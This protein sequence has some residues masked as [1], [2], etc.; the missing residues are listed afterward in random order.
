M[1]IYFGRL[2]IDIVQAFW[3]VV[4]VAVLHYDLVI[5]N[6]HGKRLRFMK[7]SINDI[8]SQKKY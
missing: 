1:L 5:I 8:L 2:R 4:K 7:M 6:I 3:H